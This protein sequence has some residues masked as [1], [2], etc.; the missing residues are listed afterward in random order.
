VDRTVVLDCK[1]AHGSRSLYSIRSVGH[2]NNVFLE[3]REFTCFCIDCMSWHPI[4]ICTNND[5]V[6]PWT[7]RTLEPINTWNAIHEYEEQE[8]D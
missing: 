3:T 2:L 4:G 5:F 7:L 1:S 8:P 6:E